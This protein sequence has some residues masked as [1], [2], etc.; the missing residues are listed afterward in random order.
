MY[1][2]LLTAF[3]LLA[4]GCM[5]LSQPPSPVPASDT[6]T[7]TDG[8]QTLAPGLERRLY[9]PD[10]DNPL[11]H[12]VALRID[13][14]RHTFRA[15][16]R[17][18]QPLD[19]VRWR[20]EL[21]EAVVLVNAN[22]FTPEHQILGLVVA[23]GAVYGQT[24]R[25]YGGMFA[26]QNGLPVIRSNASQPYAGEMLEQAV[27]GFPMLVMNGQAAYSN[28]AADRATRRT[29]VGQDRQ[30]R[31]ILLVTPLLG[32]TLR[33]LSAYLPTTDLDLLIAFN[34]D[35]GGSS[36]LSVSV[37]NLPEYRVISRDPVPVVLAVYG[38]G[39]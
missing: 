18:G 25:D 2:F 3:M 33:D 20:Q 22:F 27:Q 13:P 14:A 35:G 26:V 8:W 23:D 15:H 12:I 11:S 6:V 1:H 17:P 38:R 16:A 7:P 19:I 9:A 28:P 39:S 29:A 21:P 24:Y 30:G 34:L 4:G 32:L 36:L 10:A 31:I 37:P 5:A